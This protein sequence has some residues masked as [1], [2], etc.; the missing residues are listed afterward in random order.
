MYIHME[1]ITKVVSKS[2]NGAIV[3]V[4]SKWMNRRVSITLAD[5]D[6]HEISEELF[7]LFKDNLKNVIGIYLYGSYA[8]NEQL[9]DSDIDIL[10]VVDKKFDLK[11][12]RFDIHMVDIHVL[13]E[14]LKKNPIIFLSI[15]REAKIIINPGLLDN[16]K[17]IKDK[18]F[19]W[20]INSTKS[21]LKIDKNLL[22]LNKKN[23]IKYASGASIYSIILRARGFYLIKCIENNKDYT[24][25]NFLDYLVNLGFERVFVDK[26]YATYRNIKINK[27]IVSNI[28]V[29]KVYDLCL[30]VE[31]EVMIYEKKK[32]S[33][34]V[35]R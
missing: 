24:N 6:I 13:E 25:K 8:R 11:P 26:I 9:E 20:F 4:P 27:S 17:K 28:L 16:L 31:K 19:S 18:D 22:E 21:A 10:I 33:G 32:K 12:S 15:I 35:N 14:G 5:L 34:K 29:D 1:Q 30:K 2:G 23:N 7:Y 3:Y